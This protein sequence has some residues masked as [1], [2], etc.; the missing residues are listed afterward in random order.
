MVINEGGLGEVYRLIK[1]NPR[2]QIALKTNLES[3]NY[4]PNKLRK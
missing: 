1:E 2:Y 4:G 3:I